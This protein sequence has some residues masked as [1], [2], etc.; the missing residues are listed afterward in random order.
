LRYIFYSIEKIDSTIYKALFS[1]IDANESLL[2][3]DTN[4]ER[5]FPPE[6]IKELEKRAGRLELPESAEKREEA[7]EEF[8]EEIMQNPEKYESTEVYLEVG[9]DYIHLLSAK[10][11]KYAK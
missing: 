10:N 11:I 9:D 2:S 6:Y 4:G 1:Y 7:I 8:K 3:F 5:L